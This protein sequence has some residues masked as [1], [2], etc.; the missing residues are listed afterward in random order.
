VTVNLKQGANK[1]QVDAAIECFTDV[2]VE[3]LERMAVKKLAYTAEE[4]AFVLGISEC[5]VYDLIR[6]EEL[7]PVIKLGKRGIRIPV[8]TLEDF[9]SR[10]GVKAS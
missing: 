1:I 10:G 2:L 5:F 8:K 9:V 7:A 3:K 6:K 4:A